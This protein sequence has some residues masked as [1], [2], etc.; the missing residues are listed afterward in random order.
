MKKPLKK[1]LW[2]SLGVLSLGLGIIGIFI[3][4]LPTTPFLLL[5]ASFFLKGSETLYRWLLNH[6]LLG[7]YIRNYREHKAIP[8]T[9][10]I[11]A[12][13]TLWAAI[14]YSMFFV[15]ENLY[16]RIILLSIA[17]GVSIHI[18]HFKT[19]EKED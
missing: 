8:L 6:K 10:K 17:A 12:V 4:L 15:T 7:T 1:Y 5:A 14:L 18:L 2:V 13:V 3:P 11:L 16:L 9:T 19:L